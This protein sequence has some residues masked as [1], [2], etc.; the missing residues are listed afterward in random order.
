MSPHF[1]IILNILRKAGIKYE[2]GKT[3]GLHDTILIPSDSEF[4]DTGVCFS[5]NE[6]GTLFAVYPYEE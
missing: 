5:F 2:I 3:E 4:Y 6:D 1:S